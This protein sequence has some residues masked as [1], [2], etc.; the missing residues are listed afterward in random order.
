MK[1]LGA[2]VVIIGGSSGMGF[3]TAKL[4]KEQGANVTIAMNAAIETLAKGL[5]LELAPIRVNAVAPGMI[6]TPLLG[7]HR[8]RA[9]QWAEASLPVKQ[10]RKRSCCI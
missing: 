10:S 4:A 8:A 6:D 2:H 9:T 1:L 7:E 5:A 3:A